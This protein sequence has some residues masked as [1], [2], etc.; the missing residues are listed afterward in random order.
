[1]KLG[2]LIPNFSATTDRSK[3]ESFYD[4]VGEENWSMV[5]SH[6]AD[7]TPVC[8]TELAE[9]RN[10]SGEFAKRNVKILAVSIDTPQTH[11]EWA[12]DIN[13]FAKVDQ[14]TE[15]PYEIIADE[16]RSLCVDLGMIDPDEINAAGVPVSCRAVLLIGPDH[17][18]KAQILYPATVGRN[19]EE[20]I[21]LID[22]VQLGYN[23]PV[24]TPPTLSDQD[25]LSKLCGGDSSKCEVKNL[26]SGKKYMRIIHGDHY[27]QN[28]Q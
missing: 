3:F 14:D 4:W 11:R 5:F 8:T 17:R 21:R 20:I 24:A 6:P 25:V 23:V 12:K 9:L 1:M 2:D 13:G 26:P 28:P 10:L 18:L 22:G 15:L 27:L 19:F 7:F 16:D